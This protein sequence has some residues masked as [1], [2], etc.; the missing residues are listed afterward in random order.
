MYQ[1]AL[2]GVYWFC[3]GA[4]VKMFMRIIRDKQRGGSL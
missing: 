2:I 4:I 1:V 3:S